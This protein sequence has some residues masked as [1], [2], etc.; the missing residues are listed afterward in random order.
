MRRHLFTIDLTLRGPVLTKSSSPSNFG[1][2]AAVARIAHGPDAG[3]PY[4]P[5]TLI[6]GKVRESL[7]EIGYADEVS[8]FFGQDTEIG[9]GNEP[10]RGRILFG[11]LIATTSGGTGTCSR[12]AIEHVLGSSQAQMLRNIETPFAA[13]ASVTFS[14]KAWYYGDA[15]AAE[16]VGERLRQGLS[17]LTQIGAN[18]TTGFGRV[19]G[20]K[21]EATDEHPVSCSTAVDV[22]ALSVALRPKG[23]LCVSK[24]KIGDNLFESDDI[25]PGN[26]IA[27]AMVETWA[28][29]CGLPVGSTLKECGTKDPVHA[30]LALHFDLIRFRHAFPALETGG[31]PTVVP[32][33]TVKVGE[34]PY[35]VAVCRDPVLCQDQKRAFVAPAFVPDW[36][37]TSDVH[38]KMGWAFPARELRV[39]TAIDPQKRMAHRGE[40]GM[41]GKLFAWEMAHPFTEDG[42]P[43]AWM[44]SIDIADVPSKDRKAVAEAIAFLL[45]QLGFLS[46]TKAV[47]DADVKLVTTP[48][49]GPPLTQGQTLMLALQTPALLADPRFQNVEGIPKFGALS[50]TEMFVLY[51]DAWTELS[52]GAIDLYHHF[53]RQFLSGGNH[54]AK[55][56]Q[57]NKAYNPWLLTAAGSVF[58][59]TVTDAEKAN[60]RLK[61]W[62]ATGL[63]LPKWAIDSYGNTWRTNFYL[64]QNGF[65]EIA[66]HVSPPTT[67]QSVNL[68]A[69]ILPPH[70]RESAAQV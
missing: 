30:E 69:S 25:I 65:G 5:G 31:R 11:D 12:N 14:G 49:S 33:S 26:M 57:R 64:P 39:R 52:G 48:V 40:N 7:L 22:C 1:L 68:T 56:F 42:T 32:L 62:L 67:T 59:F 13:G 50:A 43:I 4:L 10:Q 44:T 23:P 54:L 66:Q 53:A 15:N 24:H 70:E 21:V 58:V 6:K 19:T 61:S 17:W 55:R 27:G 20:V 47:C 3:K 38:K 46:K 45:P 35:D 51:R 2:D 41:G 63:K 28:A 8:A 60:E 36:K 16:S 18:R 37:D 9:S 29:L 34:I